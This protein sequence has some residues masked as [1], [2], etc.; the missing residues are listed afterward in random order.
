LNPTKGIITHKPEEKG[1]FTVGNLIMS[2]S[3]KKVYRWKINVTSKIGIA[4]G[5]CESDLSGVDDWSRP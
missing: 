1:G 4:F 3:S 5:I 2:M